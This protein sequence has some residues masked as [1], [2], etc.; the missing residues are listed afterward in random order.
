MIGGDHAVRRQKIEAWDQAGLAEELGAILDA[1]AQDRV[2]ID[3][4]GP[5]A[6][7]TEG[8]QALVEQV[9]DET[10]LETDI[11]PHDFER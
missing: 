11:S 4:L 1:L 10:R 5:Q 7:F 2:R 8:Y 3:D 6:Q 9:I